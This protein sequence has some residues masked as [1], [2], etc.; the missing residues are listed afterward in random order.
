MRESFT[1]SLRYNPP[2]DWRR[3]IGFFA[4][5]AT[6]GVEFVDAPHAYRR[7]ID[8]NGALGTLDVSDDAAGA[9]L[10]VTVDGDAARFGNAI[11]AR[12]ARMFDVTADCTTI[13]AHLARDPW[14]SPLVAAAPGLRVP[15]AWS[16]F[17]IA[18]RAIVGQQVSVKAATTILGRLVER[19]GVAI[20]AS[21]DRF[22]ARVPTPARVAATVRLFPTP[23]ALADA[24]LSGIGMPGKRVAA[25][26]GF[27]RMLADEPIALDDPQADRAALREALLALPGIGPWTVEY[28]AMRALRDPDAWPGTDLVLAQSIVTRDATLAKASQQRTRSDAWRPFRAYAALH[29]W[30]DFAAKA[31]AARGG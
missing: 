23:A 28:V 31:N 6:P 5:R 3:I 11:A 15:G 13:D 20:E 12:V 10:R 14:F 27:A 4:A 24:D 22:V 17:E 9:S 2:Y 8:V 18:V 1:A 19:F 21:G 26:Q 29:L 16:A 7:A 25:L 30:T